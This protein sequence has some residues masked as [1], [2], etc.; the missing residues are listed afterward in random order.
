MAIQEHVE[1]LKRGVDAWNDW[2]DT[3]PFIEPDLSGIDLF[4]NMPLTRNQRLHREGVD[5]VNVD[6]RAVNLTKTD[7]YT[8]FR[9]GANLIGANLQEAELK[10]AI[11]PEANLTN[12]YLRFANF[13]KAD[14]RESI[15]ANADL[16]FAD[17]TKADLRR[18]DL[19]GANLTGAEPW[20]AMLYGLPDKSDN[21]HGQD[22]KA[23]GTVAALL[24]EIQ[25]LKKV[26]TGCAFYFRGESKTGWPLSPSVMRENSAAENEA[27]M[28]LD[29]T[30]RLP[31]EFTGM[32]S[33]LEK[34]VLSQHYK[35][36]TRFLDIT[37]NPLVALFNA[38]RENTKW[39][40]RLHIFVV[41]PNLVKS[42][43]SDAVSVITNFARLS[44]YEQDLL[45]GWP[46]SK[47]GAEYNTPA[48]PNE[49]GKRYYNAMVRLYQFIR[50]EK[51]HFEERIDPRV[52]YRVFV[53]E[54]QESIQRVKAQSGAFLVSA[55]HARFEPL[56][57]RA[58]VQGAL[59]YNFYPLRIPAKSKLA[60]LEELQ[61]M[62]ISE[63]TLFPSLESSA[64]AINKRYS[65]GG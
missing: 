31:G 16:A 45:L 65:G 56:E 44:Q 13:K 41:P 18:A 64:M 32:T 59:D 23:L 54:P 8:G 57:V 51:P 63:E 4:D 33:A 9:K 19:T 17:L 40:G 28:L 14:L 24:R 6:F 1:I 3:N 55:F 62:E 10:G 48:F 38:C 34:W 50:E 29:L 42:Y 30:S 52:F 27:Q 25:R 61:M 43:D 11:L 26:H 20:K 5:L 49:I 58:V 36:K 22:D 47:Q 37:T 12:A 21:H 7:F 35:L 15:L 53:V 60:I 2:R 46:K 39:A